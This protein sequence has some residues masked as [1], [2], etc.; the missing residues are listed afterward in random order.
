MQQVLSFFKLIRWLNLLFIA[1]TQSLFYYCIVHPVFYAHQPISH[2]SEILFGILV[3]SSLLVAAGGYIINDYFDV[4]IDLVNKPDRM[5]V[6][7]SIHRRWAI[8]WHLIFSFTGTLL[9]FYIGLKNGNWLIGWA[10]F[11]AVLLLW[12]YSTSFKKQLLSGNVL[13]SLLTAW[14]VM[15]VYFFA[16]MQPIHPA[17]TLAGDG[18]KLL[19]LA[20]VYSSFAFLISLIREMIKDMEDVEGDRK[21]GC[22]TM[23]IAWGLQFS[24]IFAGVWLV[25]LLVLLLVSMFYILYFKMWLPALYHF[26]LIVLPTIYCLRMLPAAVTA[27]QFSVLSKWIKVIMFTG[28]LSMLFFKYFS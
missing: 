20:L 3:A 11:A 12:F 8:L 19:R 13:I 18:D 21:Y 24:K 7:K 14:V 27:H 10:N 17:S 2:Q 28:I 4:N 25:I 16:I 23:P 5:V 9:G 26:I 22:R 1:I 6:D 15:V